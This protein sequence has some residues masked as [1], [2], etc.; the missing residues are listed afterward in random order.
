MERQIGLH[1]T[2]M[3]NAAGEVFGKDFQT[4]RKY[5][6]NCRQPALP[7]IF[8]ALGKIYHAPC[9]DRLFERFHLTLAERN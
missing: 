4:I 6:A 1:S 2:L 9:G 3:F 8:R 7:E 5:S